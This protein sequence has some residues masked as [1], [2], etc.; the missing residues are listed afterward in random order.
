[1]AKTIFTGS[2][3]LVLIIMNGHVGL[4]GTELG[5]DSP[6]N[7]QKTF[8]DCPLWNYQCFVLHEP[9]PCTLFYQYCLYYKGNT[10]TLAAA[11]T[12]AQSS[13]P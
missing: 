7:S 8:I 13:T 11:P 5:K 2:L 3:V 6:Y 9:L 4:G 12:V 1:M 10:N